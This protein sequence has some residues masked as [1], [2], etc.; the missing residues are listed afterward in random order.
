MIEHLKSPQRQLSELRREGFCILKQA[1]E[2]ADVEQACLRLQRI[3]DDASEGVLVSRGHAYGIRNV[4]H[5]WPAVPALLQTPVLRDFIH[6]VLGASAGVV[7]VLF[8]DKPPGRSWT[9]PWHR[10]RTIAVRETPKGLQEFQNSTRKAGVPHVVAPPW[11]L[12]NMLTLRISLDPMTLGNGP[13]VVIP[14]SHLPE[15]TDDGDLGAVGKVETA[16]S[17]IAIGSHAN[18]SPNPTRIETV[19]CELG[20]VFAMRPLLAHSSLKSE[21]NCELRRR[22]LHIELCNQ[23]ELPEGLQWHDFVSL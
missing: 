20:D 13:L 6:Q 9:L 3:L 17:E 14:G 1:V 22:V 4:L 15:S 5:H 19:Q 23:R 16:N 12:T 11:L 7:R 18:R 2:H 8:F 21:E 10:D